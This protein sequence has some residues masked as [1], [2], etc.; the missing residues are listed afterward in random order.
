MDRRISGWCNVTVGK[1][2]NGWCNGWCNGFSARIFNAARVRGRSALRLDGGDAGNT[3]GAFVGT[4]HSSARLAP[5]PN[6]TPPARLAIHC[7]P[8][9]GSLPSFDLSTDHP[10]HLIACAC[11][12]HDER[13]RQHGHD[14]GH[15]HHGRGALARRA[16]CGRLL[17]QAA[18]RGRGPGQ[19]SPSLHLPN[20][21]QCSNLYRYE[22]RLS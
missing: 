8:L 7:Q 21:C 5:C 22:M 11:A 4:R 9:C 16:R 2:S 18:A 15:P 14:R 1:V 12:R 3:T 20:Q 17:P 10:C 6:R 19:D 13:R